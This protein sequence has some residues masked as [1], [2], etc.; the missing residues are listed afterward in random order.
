MQHL[1]IAATLATTEPSSPL[2]H[3]AKKRRENQK[4]ETNANADKTRD[5]RGG[6]ATPPPPLQD[7]VA[8]GINAMPRNIMGKGREGKGYGDI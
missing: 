5:E 7:P 1:D 6:G 4:A 3:K 2:P 8:I